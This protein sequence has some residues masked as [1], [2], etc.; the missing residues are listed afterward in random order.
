MVAVGGTKGTLVLPAVYLQALSS[1]VVQ[2]FASSRSEARDWA[3]FLPSPFAIAVADASVNFQDNIR[4]GWDEAGVP[5]QFSNDSAS[6]RIWY[7]ADMYFNVSG[8][9][10]R[11]AEVAFGG[12]DGG[13]DGGKCVKGSFTTVEQQRGSGGNETVKGGDKEDGAVRGVRVGWM[14]IVVCLLVG[15]LVV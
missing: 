8:L 5:T 1:Y 12:E 10:E 14:A 15:L 2:N 13:M 3:D 4:A 7:Q 6:C 11:A 9:W